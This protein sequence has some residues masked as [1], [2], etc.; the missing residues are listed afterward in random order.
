MNL[1]KTLRLVCSSDVIP[2]KVRFRDGPKPIYDLKY[3][4]SLGGAG[5][6]I[7]RGICLPAANILNTNNVLKP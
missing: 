7:E 1:M 2:E 3:L 4:L 5:L 6:D